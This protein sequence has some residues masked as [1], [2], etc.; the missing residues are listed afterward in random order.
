LGFLV[1]GRHSHLD[2]AG[3]SLDQKIRELPPPEELVEKL[4][5]EESWRMVLNSLVICLFARGIYDVETVSEALDPLGIPVPPEELHRLGRDI[6]KQRYSLKIQ[7][8]FDPTELKAPRRILE[9][10][11]PHGTL[12]E[13][14]FE[15]GLKH[16]SNT[17]REWDII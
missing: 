12:E 13:E 14:Y 10:P 8:G 16:F 17:L 2:N 4:I 11:T 6:Y 3:Y 9:V 7:M 1:G 5:K 15:R